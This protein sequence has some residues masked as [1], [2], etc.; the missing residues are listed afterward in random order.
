MDPLGPLERRGGAFTRSLTPTPPPPTSSPPEDDDEPTPPPPLLPLPLRLLLLLLLLLLLYQKLVH[1]HQTMAG[2]SSNTSSTAAPMPPLFG[3][4]GPRSSRSHLPPPS[5]GDTSLHTV[6]ARQIC[7]FS[8]TPCHAI[9]FSDPPSLHPSL[10]P[11]FPQPL[12]SR[13]HPRPVL[14]SFSFT[15]P[16]SF[17]LLGRASLALPP[18]CL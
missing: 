2:S 4:D 17:P 15:L 12:T 7:D 11:S 8:N 5:R 18:S 13:L 6:S 1:E 16:P 10:L 9:P 14:P 3:H